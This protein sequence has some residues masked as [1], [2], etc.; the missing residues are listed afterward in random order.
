MY[1]VYTHTPTHTLA[2]RAHRVP[3]R[4]YSSSYIIR[5]RPNTPF[6]LPRAHTGH[7]Y[8]RH[9]H[10]HTGH[11]TNHTHRSTHINPATTPPPNRP[12]SWMDLQTVG[13]NGFHD[14]FA[15]PAPHAKSQHKYPLNVYHTTHAYSAVIPHHHYTAHTHAIPLLKCL[16]RRITTVEWLWTLCT[17][18][19]TLRR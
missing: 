13:W 14:R 4:S 15:S 16:A 10:T 18:C 7:I 12:L 17:A 9:T 3:V 5:S 19:Q 8:R 2:R 1:C 11:Q 6:H